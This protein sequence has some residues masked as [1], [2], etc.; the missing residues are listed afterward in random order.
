MKGLLDVRNR[1][2]AQERSERA[3]MDVKRRELGGLT[4]VLVSFAARRDDD[5]VGV[6]ELMIRTES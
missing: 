6:R 2:M 5:D 4:I 1:K 3:L